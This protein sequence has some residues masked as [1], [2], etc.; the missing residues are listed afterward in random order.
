VCP[1]FFVQAE[2]L[3]LNP[4][5]DVEACLAELLAEQS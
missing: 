3:W 4:L 1:G 2:W 5:P